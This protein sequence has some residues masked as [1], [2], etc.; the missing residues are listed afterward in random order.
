MTF[1]TSKKKLLPS[2][3]IKTNSKHFMKTSTFILDFY[4][5][6]N[7]NWFLPSE[8]LVGSVLLDS[9]K[10]ILEEEEDEGEDKVSVKGYEKSF[11]PPVAIL[12]DMSKSDYLWGIPV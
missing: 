6:S 3:Q 12:F 11:S 10:D 5:F 2:E 4:F 9:E 1:L 8:L 7:Q